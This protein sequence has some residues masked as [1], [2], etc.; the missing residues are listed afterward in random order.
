M[1]GGDM[2]P[3]VRL[4]A[5]YPAA[6][7][8]AETELLLLDDEPG[9]EERR[10]FAQELREAL[11]ELGLGELTVTLEPVDLPHGATDLDD[12]YRAVWPLIQ[13][14]GRNRDRELVIHFSSGTPAM[15]FTLTLAAYCS[16][17]AVAK[18]YETSPRGGVKEMTLP[19]VLA[20]REIRGRDHAAP[21]NRLSREARKSL[22]DNTV[23]DNLAVQTAYS[24]LFKAARSGHW[25]PPRI[26]IH[27]PSG[28]GKWHAAKQ[29]ALWRD[30]P[31]VMLQDGVDD[32]E[33]PE[34][35]T[36]L[37]RHLDRW[38][39]N[40][41]RRLA[42]L[43]ETRDDIALVASFRSDR[44][45]HAPLRALEE[46]GLL[47][48]AQIEMPALGGRDDVQA[49]GEAIARQLGMADGKLRAR[50]AT[51]WISDT[52]PGGMH[53]LKSLLATA[54]LQSGGKHAEFSAF[55][56]ASQLRKGDDMLDRAWDKLVALANG[57]SDI[58]MDELVKWIEYALVFKTRQL[59]SS[60]EKTGERLGISQ[61][62]VS[63]I[64]RNRPDAVGQWFGASAGREPS[65]G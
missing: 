57:G 24:A 1:D 6:L 49:V 64:L 7:V 39:P 27:G 53:D 55:N 59:V 50:M 30:R 54:G 61:P 42:L 65:D 37:I 17:R 41:L 2:S 44:A 11:P 23:V 63:E 43:S 8:P 45:P 28:S 16:R 58:G 10:Q 47:G 32:L 31:Q 14:L 60:Q 9:N 33:I 21:V 25:P 40:G 22:Q 56:R 48:A 51:E 62:R 38:S 4:L 15:Q 19:Y 20:A 5:S 13:R 36:V 35:A 3:V 26:R 34:E 52:Y 29:F 46:S 18:L 12:L